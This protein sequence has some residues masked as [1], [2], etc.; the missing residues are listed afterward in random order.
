MM[1]KHKLLAQIA[2]LKAELA[3]KD[4]LPRENDKM[5][6]EQE[7]QTNNLEQENELLQAD[8]NGAARGKKQESEINS[9]FICEQRLNTCEGEQGQLKTSKGDQLCQILEKH[10]VKA[11]ERD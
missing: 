5:L 7:E 11:K 8:Q 10:G 9:I 6:S 2:S 3:K 4:K 1:S